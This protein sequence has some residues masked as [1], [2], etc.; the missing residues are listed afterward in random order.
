[1]E[2]INLQ[3]FHIFKWNGKMFLFD[4]S[5]SA[6]FEIKEKIAYEVLKILKKEKNERKVIKQLVEQRKIKKQKVRE[7]LSE[8]SQLSKNSKEKNV[9]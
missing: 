6:L 8:I 7:I 2:V 4:I 9:L 1:M 5:S 3:E